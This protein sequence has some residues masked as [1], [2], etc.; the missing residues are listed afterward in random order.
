MTRIHSNYIIIN[1]TNIVIR[2]ISVRQS[3]I[4]SSPINHLKY[5]PQNLR[6]FS[7]NSRVD[8]RHN[9]EISCLQPFLQSSS[10]TTDHRTDIRE[11][12]GLESRGEDFYTCINQVCP[13]VVSVSLSKSKTVLY[14]KV[15]HLDSV[16]CV[17]GRYHNNQS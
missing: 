11:I 7:N 6:V 17:I 1:S 9:H 15:S 5:L 13:P 3:S 12:H 4:Y 2:R 14:I 8:F 10:T 16:V